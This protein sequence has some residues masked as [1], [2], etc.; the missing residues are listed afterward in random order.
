MNGLLAA[1]AVANPVLTALL[2]II[3][4]LEKDKIK[5]RSENLEAALKSGNQELV[6]TV[7]G[8]EENFENIASRLEALSKDSA[9]SAETFVGLSTALT[10]SSAV[11]A[12]ALDGVTTGLENHAKSVE[13]LVTKLSDQVSTTASNSIGELAIRSEETLRA[14]AAN[15]QA[16]EFSQDKAISSIESKA[17]LT[18]QAVLSHIKSLENAQSNAIETLGINSKNTLGTV[19][20][21][22]KKV[23][24]AQIAVANAVKDLQE[25]L[26]ITVSL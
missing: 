22:V 20:D 3:V 26:K 6:Q 2:T 1:M 16:I 4:F 8:Q 15:V 14:V 24:V 12:S 19:A 7:A 21:E 5:Q 9:K 23:E 10:E 18:L 11:S 17:E 25:T 13:G